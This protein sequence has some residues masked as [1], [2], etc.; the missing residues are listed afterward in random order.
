VNKIRVLLAEDHETVRQ[1][2]R[3]LIDAQADMEVVGEAGDGHTAVQRARALQPTVALV[4]IS[5]PDMNGLIATRTLRETMPAL[6]IVVLTR[7]GDEAY[8]QEL[9]SAGARAY[10]LKQSPS[11]ELLKAIRAAARGEDYLDS[12]LAARVTGAYLRKHMKRDVHAPT[13]T[14]RETEVL[15]LMAWGHSNKDIA[16]QLDVSV[17]TVEVHKAN[18]MRKLHMRGRI[19]VV[20]FALLQGWLSEE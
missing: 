20:R 19:D 1:G 2:L 9:L 7:Y 16:A 13:I 8:V 10:V 5:M 3:L 12:S 4:D 17:K 6:A 11:A 15:R 14:D 18:A